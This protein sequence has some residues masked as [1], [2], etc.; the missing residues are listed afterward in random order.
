LIFI[1]APLNPR[2]L[3]R[4]GFSY[5]GNSH[6]TFQD[7][8]LPTCQLHTSKFYSGTDYIFLCHVTEYLLLLLLLLMEVYISISYN[9]ISHVVT[10]WSTIY[11]ACLQNLCS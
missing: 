6:A 10:Q 2:P 4:L 9:V 11:L 3:N 5:H 1:P 7:G 8:L